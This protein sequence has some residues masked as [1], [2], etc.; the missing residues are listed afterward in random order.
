MR[1]VHKSQY[2]PRG[3]CCALPMRSCAFWIC[4]VAGHGVG[5]QG[6][7]PRARRGIGFGELVGAPGFA[8]VVRPRQAR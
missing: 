5:G 6:R 7:V 2:I 3:C 1:Y 4:G 8:C